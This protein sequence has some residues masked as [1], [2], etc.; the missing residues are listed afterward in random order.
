LWNGGFKWM[1]EDWRRFWENLTYSGNFSTQCPSFPFIPLI[2]KQAL[3]CGRMG[4][5]RGEEAQCARRCR[6]KCRR[7]VCSGMESYSI[8]W[9]HIYIH[10][11]TYTGRVYSVTG[12]GIAYFIAR[13]TERTSQWASIH[14]LEN[15]HE[16]LLSPPN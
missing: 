7:Q 13:P 11:H 6:V 14:S 1:E 15:S 2:P 9:V 16:Q 8:P 10:T 12:Y 3:R 4:R 5:G